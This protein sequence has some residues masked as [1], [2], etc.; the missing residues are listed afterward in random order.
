MLILYLSVKVSGVVSTPNEDVVSLLLYE[1]VTVPVTV[2][3]FLP[4]A[5]SI[6]SL[7][8][9]SFSKAI[10]PSNYLQSYFLQNHL[11]I[12]NIDLE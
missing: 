2:G 5:T 1:P 8:S 7:L 3:S 11:M 9:F 10:L 4:I 12:S 6:V